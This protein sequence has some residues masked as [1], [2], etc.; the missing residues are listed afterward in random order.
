MNQQEA[1]VRTIEKLG[2]IATLGQLYDEVFKTKDCKWETKTPF[3]TIRR[4]VQL[5]KAIYKIKP[6]LYGLVSKKS[7][8]EAHGIVETESNRKTA[9]V[10]GFGH[11][12]YQALLLKV[13]TLRQLDCWCPNQDKNK[14][15]LSTTLGA[16]R[17]VQ[18]LPAFS[19]DW[20]VKRSATVDV[21]W[22]NERKMPGSFFEIEHGTDMHNSLVKLNELQDFHARMVIVAHNKRCNEFTAKVKL[23]AFRDIADRMDFLSYE[24]LG[25]DYEHEIEASSSDFKL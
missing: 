9:A 16:L 24:R 7:E 6:G 13:A 3:A 25:K 10:T 18:D 2:G 17:T 5:H 14:A 19:Y 20:L 23:S 1:V 8:H 4:I 22:F 15:V 12:Y 11:T 21:I